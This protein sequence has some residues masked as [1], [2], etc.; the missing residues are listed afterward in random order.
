MTPILNSKKYFHG[1]CSVGIVCPGVMAR[2]NQMNGRSAGSTIDIACY[3]PAEVFQLSG[4]LFG[5]LEGIQDT[6]D[7]FMET[8]IATARQN[9]AKCTTCGSHW[10]WLGMWVE[11]FKLEPDFC[12]MLLGA[13]QSWR[14]L[15][16][17]WLALRGFGFGFPLISVMFD[18][19]V[20]GRLCQVCEI[21]KQY[22][23]Q[24]IR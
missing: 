22:G 12:N 2:H 15:V 5:D 10:M 21:Q 18:G 11:A 16:F 6:Y 3:C 4:P 19:M 13:A 23:I 14:G 20:L 7:S 9:I 17:G 1:L 24:M 8:K